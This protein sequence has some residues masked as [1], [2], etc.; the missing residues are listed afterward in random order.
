MEG[1]NGK[2]SFLD[3]DIHNMI[4]INT[5]Y[6][7]SNKKYREQ[8]M[9]KYFNNMIK[10]KLSMHNNICLKKNFNL[11]CRYILFLNNPTLLEYVLSNG[12]FNLGQMFKENMT[13]PHIFHQT[14]TMLSQILFFFVTDNGNTKKKTDDFLAF[15]ENDNSIIEKMIKSLTSRDLFI[16]FN[17]EYIRISHIHIE[18]AIKICELLIK[19]G[20]VLDYCIDDNNISYSFLILLIK[21]Y[22]H[23]KIYH[24][25]ILSIINM[26]LNSSYDFLLEGKDIDYPFIPF[27]RIHGSDPNDA[28]HIDV[29]TC[30][31]VMV[32]QSERYLSYFSF[33]FTE[34]M[35]KKIYDLFQE[36]FIKRA[37][38]TLNIINLINTIS[39]PIAEEIQPNILSVPIIRQI[40]IGNTDD[41]TNDDHDSY[42]LNDEHDYNDY[43]N[44][45]NRYNDY[46]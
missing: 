14:N 27:S 28:I 9:I 1:C 46:D 33:H 31:D 23:R 38:K 43:R 42:D 35:R 4:S 11:I 24:D 21:N 34:D 3:T 5:K 30:V 12:M 15:I 40:N 17:W 2:C 29:V 37:E 41:D 13:N 16:I 39:F 22:I 6:I 45:G 7:D 26:F 20:T 19:Y 44:E 36:Y 32:K 18:N 25:D 10:P 8:K